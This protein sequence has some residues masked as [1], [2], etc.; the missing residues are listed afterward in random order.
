M[1][2]KIFSVFP[3]INSALNAPIKESGIARRTVKG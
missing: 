1:K 3:V 2:L